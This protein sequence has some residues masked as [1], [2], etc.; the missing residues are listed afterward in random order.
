MVGSIMTALAWFCL[1]FLVVIIVQEL[2]DIR[3]TLETVIKEFRTTYIEF[4]VDE[5]KENVGEDVESR[6]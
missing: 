1:L 6:E 3:A 5:T 2:A 4:K